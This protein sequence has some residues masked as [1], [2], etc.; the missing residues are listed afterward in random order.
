[1]NVRRASGVR[2]NR[3]QLDALTETWPAARLLLL[4][5]R[6]RFGILL[7][8]TRRETYLCFTEATYANSIEV[9]GHL[10]LSRI[11]MKVTFTGC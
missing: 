1:M 2:L 3:D 7:L 6:D 11:V 8:K 10:P 5:A 4:N 9:N